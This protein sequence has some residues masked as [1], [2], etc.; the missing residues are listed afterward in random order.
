MEKL[1]NKITQDNDTTCENQRAND[2]PVANIIIEG[3]S[4]QLVCNRKYLFAAQP[5]HLGQQTGVRPCS[6]GVDWIG[7]KT[8]LKHS[9]PWPHSHTQSNVISSM[10]QIM[11][12][13]I[14][15][16]CNVLHSVAVTC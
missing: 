6:S 9:G 7:T 16:Q 5:C 1:L 11:C 10:L 8:S 3:H 4:T 14:R 2:G 12:C 15:S 13:S